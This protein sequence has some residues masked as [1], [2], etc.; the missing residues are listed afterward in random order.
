MPPS[1]LLP[2]ALLC[3]SQEPAPDEGPAAPE[4][5][6]FSDTKGQP[7]VRVR[8]T[9][10]GFNDP[11]MNE[12]S[13]LA[14]PDGR[15]VAYMV[16]AGDGLAVVADGVRGE[17]FEGI[18]DQSLAFSSN[19][20][21]LA[22]VGT[23]PGVQCVVIDGKVHEYRGV[24]KH[25]IVFSSDGEHYGWAAVRD[26]KHVVVVDGVERG[27]YDNVA[28][29]GLLF[30]PD[31][32]RFA[33]GVTSGEKQ[34]II[35]DGEEGP[36]FDLVGGLQFS[37]NSQH[38]VYLAVKD[39]KRHVVVDTE[40]YGP[41]DE[42]RTLKPGGGMDSMM[43]VLEI[44]TDGSRVGFVGS[45]GEEWFVVIDGKET[46]PFEKCIGLSFSP[47]GGR[48]AYLASRGEGWVMVVDGEERPG[49]GLQ[50]LSF[51]PD[52]KRL[53]SVL[54]RDGQS[55]ALVDG[56]AG[57]G[58]E[59]IEEP[60][61][62]FS[63]DGRHVAYLAKV[64]GENVVVLDERESA[65]FKRLGKLALAFIPNG[66]DV[67]YSIRRGE[68]EALV[69]AGQEGPTVKSYRSLTFSPDGEHYAY[70]AELDTDRWVVVAD[71][72]VYGPGGRLAPGDTQAYNSLGRRTPR[73]SPDGK[74]LAWV[75]LRDTGWLAVVDG[76]ESK[77]FNI[78]MRSTLDFSPDGQHV[79]FVA[80]RGG[81]KMIVVDNFEVDGG[82]DGFLHQSDLA[83]DGPRRFSIRA[84][85]DPKYVLVEVEI[86]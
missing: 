11:A 48:A 7:R 82:W 23:R 63:H 75:A 19:G 16:M 67:L 55:F 42:L 56:Q 73:F 9:L 68:R 72:N 74:R 6:T 81:R 34:L 3:L 27:P 28:P 47:E 25:G 46:G 39:D 50:S 43:D 38:A 77:P 70:A 22:Y 52:G 1:L 44:S 13:F 5:R 79:V 66:S 8:E 71:G 59:T 41:Y 4:T 65:P 37:A 36:L 78:V 86:L 14:S 58:Y 15:R 69:I 85:R 33:Y 54:R 29:Q 32:K 17:L 61:I 40:V 26:S 76:I 10:I 57:K 31:G 51:S 35:T 53:A 62:R 30:S 80:A 20:K 24:S 18:A 45:R 21:H 2:L 60:G 84:S 12:E 64:Q 49:G 83:W